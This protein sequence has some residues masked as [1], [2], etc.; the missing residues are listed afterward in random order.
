MPLKVGEKAP[1]FTATADDGTLVTMHDLHKERNLVLY[2]YPKDETIGCVA[3]ACAFRD[4]WER[5]VQLGAIVAGV[6]SDS[7]GSHAAFKRRHGLPFYLLSDPNSEIRRL[8][9]ADGL[10]L[11]ARVTYVIDIGEVIRGVFKS[12]LR[13]RDHVTRALEY[14]SKVRSTV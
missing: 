2:F 4:N 13:A 10:L 12:Q 1:D 5:V 9:R 14:L 3:E 6:S 11:P 8:Y 7:P